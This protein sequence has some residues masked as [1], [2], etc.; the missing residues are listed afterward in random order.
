M[1]M[2]RLVNIALWFRN[3]GVNKNNNEKATSFWNVD[4]EKN[5]KNTV[6]GAQNKQWSFAIGYS[7]TNTLII[8]KKKKIWLFSEP[9]K[10]E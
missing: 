3:L 2:L 5:A 6:D 4:A 9:Y 8:N 10:R 1:R 7:N